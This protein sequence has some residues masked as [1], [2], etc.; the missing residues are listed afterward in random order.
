M[1]GSFVLTLSCPEQPG[2]VHAVTTVL[3]DHGCDITEH[4]QFDD[5]MNGKLF[6]RTAFTAP[7]GGCVADALRTGFASIADAFAM[8]WQLHDA[9]HRTRILIMASKFDHCL[10]DLLYRW[11]TGSLGGQVAAV[12]S[13]HQDLAHLADT[14]RVP[15]V[16]IPVTADSKPAAE[17]HLLQVIDQQDI[18]L[19][20]L[21]RYMQVLSDPLC[22]TLHGR[23]I[24]IHHS[25]LPSFTGA[26]P[27][28]Q[29]YERGVK[30]VGATAHYVTAELDEG[31]IIEQELTRVDHRRAPEDLIAVGRDAERLALA[32][33][34]TWHC[35]HRILLNGN[36]TI[37]FN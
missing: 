13:N 10:T 9:T 7:A 24:N 18:D 34:V 4:Q 22:R 19:V 12:V 33:A 5:P 3:N 11:R 16:H 1:T 27:Y 21:A 35:Q 30:Y 37:V 6:L 2:I 28:H 25:F 32:R 31:P 23:A 29:A 17:H 26:K 15:F 20:V 36:R 14:A 8:T